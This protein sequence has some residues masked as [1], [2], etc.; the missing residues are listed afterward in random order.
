MSNPE[1]TPSAGRAVRPLSLAG[2]LLSLKLLAA[3]ALLLAGVWPGAAQ[4][5]LNVDWQPMQNFAPRTQAAGLV[6]NGRMWVIGGAWAMDVWSSLDGHNWVQATGSPGFDEY[7]GVS[8]MVF[9]NKMWLLDADDQGYL[10]T[11]G[12]GRSWSRADGKPPFSGRAGQACVTFKNKMW[13]IGGGLFSD[14]PCYND[15]WSSNE[16]GTSWTQVSAAAPFSARTGHACVVLNDKLFVIGG[17]NCH[18]IWSSEDGTSWTLV[19]D[20]PEFGQRMNHSALVYD[21]KIWVVGGRAGDVSNTQVLFSDIWNSS[22]GKTWDKV[23]DTTALGARYGQVGLVFNDA[24]WILGGV[25]QTDEMLEYEGLNDVWR[26]TNGKD[27][28]RVDDSPP[29]FSP[30][31]AHTSLVYADKMWVIGGFNWLDYNQG[32][33]TS[34]FMN[35]VW[36]SSDGTTWT[37]A[38]AHADF[39]L[40]S[41]HTS[42]VFDQKMWVI[43]GQT[44]YGTPNFSTQAIGDKLNDVWSST[45]GIKWNQA[46]AGAAFPL[47]S[48]HTSLVFNDK[49]WVIGGEGGVPYNPPQSLADVWQSSNGVDWTQTTDNAFPGFISGRW[50]HSSVVYDNKMWVI[51]GAWNFPRYG[52]SSR[53]LLNDVWS[54]SDGTSWTCVTP[55]TSFPPRCGH[56]SL[57]YDGK[58]WVLGGNWWTT[59]DWSSLNTYNDAWWSTDGVHWTQA[60]PAGPDFIPRMFPSSLVFNNRMWILGAG[61][62]N[63][64]AFLNDV[65]ASVLRPDNAARG[66]TFY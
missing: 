43:G 61:T 44:Q 60:A 3:L 4:A 5:R 2:F 32:L 42:L 1:F 56:T 28:T 55:A 23:A 38:T 27:W 46:T 11:S 30:R 16:D 54:S 21:G 35:D 57:V 15:V 37:Q 9:N 10:R 20:A 17:S 14:Y 8:G 31:F 62:Y 22:D 36:R 66:W 24:L 39:W 7:L 48:K 25:D 53:N 64:G 40:R 58:M 12:N 29:R 13:A 45:D 50:G 47:R 6:F 18:D 41:N 52:S 65:W 34:A 59:S 63:Y 19:T 33:S 49:M 26:S 51:G